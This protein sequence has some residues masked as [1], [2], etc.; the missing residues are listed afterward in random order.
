MMRGPNRKTMKAE[1]ISAAP[2]R[3]VRYRNRLKTWKVSE[4]SV[5]Q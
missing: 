1:V 4:Y 3:K 2:V 5:S